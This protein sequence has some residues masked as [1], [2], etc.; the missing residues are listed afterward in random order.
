MLSIFWDARGVLYTEFLTKG[1]T[2]NSDRYY[3]TIRSLKQRFRSRIRTERNTFLLHHDNARPHCSARTQEAIT[4]LKF[5]KGSTPSLQPRFGTVRLLVVPK[6]EGDVLKV[7]IFHRMPKLRQL[8][9]NGSPANQ[10]LSS[11]KK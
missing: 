11:W 2:V 10:K 4:S 6:I 7:N 3:A 8:C 5:T 9:A 1:S